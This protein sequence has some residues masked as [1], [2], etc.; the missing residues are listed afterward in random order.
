MPPT[1]YPSSQPSSF[2]ADSAQFSSV[3]TQWEN[4]HDILSIL[5]IIGGDVVQRAVAQLAGSRFSF[6]P[7]AFSFGWVAY[8]IS[9]VCSAIGDGRLMPAV[10]GSFI[11]VNAKNG[12]T[13]TIQSWVLARLVRDHRSHEGGKHS[14]SVFFYRTS[15]TRP[16][17]VT[18]IDWVYCSGMAVMIVQAGIAVIPGVLHDNWVT[19]ILTLTGTVLALA[20]G[21]WPQWYAEKW[22]ARPLLPGNKKGEVVI[23]TRGNGSK[24]A[25]VIINEHGGLRLEDLAAE[26]DVRSQCTIIFTSLLAVLWIVHLLVVA[27]LQNDAWYLLAVGALGMTQNVVA[28]GARRSPGALGIHLEKGEVV[29]KEKVFLTLQAAEAR[30]QHVGLSLL[31]IFFPGGLRKEEEDWR[32]SKLAEYDE[33]RSILGSVAM[34]VV[35]SDTD[36]KDDVITSVNSSP[37]DN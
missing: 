32:Q 15:S 33:N 11:L 27:S 13:R 30:Q 16:I 9:A 19:L 23:L 29:H 14:L 17:G 2:L 18:D 5:M 34:P 25:I 8:S 4:P 10:E 28:A 6:T 21:A 35:E 20:G 7:V 3:R 12:Y 1:C 22:S 26:R 24:E 36:E 37:A 31:P